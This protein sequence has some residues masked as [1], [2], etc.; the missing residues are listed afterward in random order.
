[1]KISLTENFIFGA[2]H[3]EYTIL[4]QIRNLNPQ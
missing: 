4:T 3:F 2:V 1:M